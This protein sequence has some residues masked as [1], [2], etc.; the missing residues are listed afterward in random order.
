MSDSRLSPKENSNMLLFPEESMT[1]RQFSHWVAVAGMACWG[2]RE[3]NAGESP[4]AKLTFGFTLYGMRKVPVLEAIKVCSEIG[5][6]SLEL[7]CMTDWPCAPET[8][9]K[10]NRVAISQRM[11][12]CGIGLASLMENVSPLADTPV[13]MSN[14][15]RLKRAC[16]LGHEISPNSTPII[17]TVLGGKPADWDQ[18][19]NKMAQRLDDWAKVAE[20][21]QSIIALKPHVGGALHTPDGAKW[22][23]EQLNS[24]WLKLAYDYSHFELR[25]I[26]LRDSLEKMLPET[27]FIHVK[28]TQGDATKFQ[29][30]LP[31][32]GRTDYR[33]Y[34][35]M[36]KKYG[37]T[38]PLVIEVSGQVHS[39]ADY[40]AIAAAKHCYANLAP[41]LMETGLWK[42]K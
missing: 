4:K 11:R 35:R 16:E 24:P 12:D 41:I 42:P 3:L 39:R 13:H 8:L 26:P 31:G 9:S 33:D 36:L 14:L 6:D 28:D 7:A 34:F 21:G 29:F 18:V 27:V 38:G 25:G 23:K 17:E 30:I 37:Y 19:R 32:D 15:E 10:A 40:D 1:R 20:A 22:L 5:Y 2:I